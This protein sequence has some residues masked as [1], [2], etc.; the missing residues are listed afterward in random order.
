VGHDL[1][2]SCGGTT[3]GSGSL[4]AGT[5]TF[6]TTKTFRTVATGINL[7]AAATTPTPASTVTTFDVLADADWVFWGDFESCT[8]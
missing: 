4:S 8:P 1:A 2:G 3:L 5:I 7:T 6:S